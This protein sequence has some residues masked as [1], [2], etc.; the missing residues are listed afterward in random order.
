[1]RAVAVD[2]AGRIVATGHSTGAASA[3]KMAVW[4]FLPDGSPDPSFGSSGV[5]VETFFTA[6]EG[7]SL[8][9]GPGDS[10]IV[11]G[12]ASSTLTTL[13]AWKL[14]SSGA[15]DPSFG[16][17]GRVTRTVVYTDFGYAVA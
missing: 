2:S 13:S 11:G 6:S 17:A 15:L 14:T 1:M 10:V 12:N 9:I 4:R 5:F 16:A 3:K 8:V 7:A